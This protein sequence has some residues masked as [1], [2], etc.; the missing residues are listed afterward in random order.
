MQP[1]F[2]LPSTHKR[3]STQLCGP[4]FLLS[5]TMYVVHL[6]LP[7]IELGVQLGRFVFPQSV[8][9]MKMY[10]FRRLFTIT[11]EQEQYT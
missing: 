8:L 9:P 7:Y 4:P 1:Y 5:Y 3:E 6:Y 10:I 2:P 11:A